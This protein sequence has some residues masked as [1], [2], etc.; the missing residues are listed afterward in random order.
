MLLWIMSQE[1][2][3]NPP[4]AGLLALRSLVCPSANLPWSRCCQKGD[5]RTQRRCL[6]PRRPR[7]SAPAALR[8]GRR[9]PR[10]WQ[11]GEEAPPPAAPRHAYSHSISTPPAHSVDEETEAGNGW[12]SAVHGWDRTPG[13]WTQACLPQVG[14]WGAGPR[15]RGVTNDC[16]P[17]RQGGGVRQALGPLPPTGHI[18]ALTLSPWRPAHI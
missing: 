9:G 12:A 17:Q 6:W 3:L 18:T 4:L 13:G 5:P 11:S 16:R 1:P 10:S 7:S 8:G 2:T 15:G 14:G